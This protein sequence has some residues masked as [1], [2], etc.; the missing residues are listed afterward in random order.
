M[1]F[2]PSKC[3]VLHVTGS[4]KTV[5]IDY[6][7]NGQVLESVPCARY[8]GVDISSGLTRNSHVGRITAKANRTLEFIPRNDLISVLIQILLQR[9]PCLFHAWP[10]CECS[11]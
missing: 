2:N 4:K 10:K 1:E 5:K 7:L 8:L 11:I 6:I 9:N 3:Q